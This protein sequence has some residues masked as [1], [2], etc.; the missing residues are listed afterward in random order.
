M[1]NK[2]EAPKDH[3]VSEQ[4]WLDRGPGY[5]LR[6]DRSRFRYNV[7][8]HLI[9]SILTR[10]AVDVADVELNHVKIESD[11][12]YIGEIDSKLNRCLNIEANIDQTS[13]A[14]QQD[15]AMTLFDQGVC[16][17]VATETTLDPSDT[18]AYDVVEMR[19]GTILEWFPREV[20]I[21]LWDDIKGKHAELVVPKNVVAVIENPFYAIMNEPN[22]TLQRLVKK[23]N[24]L[25]IV[26][27]ELASGK[28][29]MIVHLPYAVKS[30]VKQQHA[31]KRLADMEFQLSH[32]KLGI[33]YMDATE[34]VTPLGRPLEN[35]LLAEIEY[36]TN[37]LYSQLGI[38][39]SIMN[40]T[41][42]EA[43]MLNYTNRTI[44]P[45]VLSITQAMRRT[46]LSKTAITQGQ[47]IS[48]FRDP[49]ALVPLSNLSDI[50]DKLSRNAIMSPNEFRPMLGMKPIAD[51]DANELRNR[52][53]P[54]PDDDLQVAEDELEDLEEGQNET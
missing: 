24:T 35:N 9:S 20:R 34:K 36:L 54:T 32:S 16:C 27:D 29:N 31:E 49:F 53:M 47:T 12:K 26:D 15:I 17:I 51:P 2:P 10:M 48:F 3:N 6:P 14:F 8:K 30:E 18:N 22:S 39:E 1:F 19:V 41:A 43:E 25:D 37:M 33:G 40:G 42:S 23:F 44:K 52:N 11:G 50:A 46:F 5:T 7:D 21:R 38:T 45:V 28:L 4:N 13:R